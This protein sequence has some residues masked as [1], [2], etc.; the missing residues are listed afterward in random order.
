ML[1]EL[2]CLCFIRRRPVPSPRRTS[3]AALLLASYA[4]FHDPRRC[5]RRSCR[6]RP[7]SNRRP[8]TPEDLWAMERVSDPKLSPDGRWVAFSVS[9]YSV[10]ENN[11]DSDLWVVP[12]DGG[13]PPRRLTWNRERTARRPGARTAGGSPSSLSAA[14]RRLSSTSSPSRRAARRSRRQSCRS[15]SRTRAGLRTASA[16]PSWPAPGPTSTTTGRLSRSGQTSRRTTRSRRRSRTAACCATG[17]P[18]APTA[19]ATT[20]SPSTSRA[21]RSRT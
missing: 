20:S 10:E 21:A 5:R 17:I 15:A 16:S 14:M 1:G 4:L 18:T 13:A 12:A 6:R 11:S 8:I 19:S 7:G 3:D 2:A 9:R